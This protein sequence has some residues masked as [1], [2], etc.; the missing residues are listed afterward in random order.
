MSDFPGEEGQAALLA[1]A[2][3]I[4]AASDAEMVIAV[5][6]QSGSY[7]DAD[8]LA[9]IVASLATLAFQLFSPWEFELVWIFVETVLVGAAGA[10]LGT[11]LPALRRLLTTAERRHAAVRT[12]AYAL[13]HEKGVAGTARRTGI[14]IYMSLLEGQAEVVPDSGVAARVET[15]AWAQRVA[16]IEEAVRGRAPAKTVA[17]RIADLKPVLAAKLPRSAGDVDEL[18]DEMVS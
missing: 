13:F 4:E 6:P 5:R 12:A 14:L 18:P 1:A 7:R 10:L 3:E 2:R 8:L 9:G 11:R 16:A 17:E 15:A